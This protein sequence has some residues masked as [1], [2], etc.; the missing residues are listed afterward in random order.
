[1]HTDTAAWQAFA[2]GLKA[3]QSQPP[4]EDPATAQYKSLLGDATTN[5]NRTYGTTLVDS[6]GNESSFASDLGAT[7][8]DR[9]KDADGAYLDPS[10]VTTGTF[11][12]GG[13][14]ASNPFSKAA[15]LVRNYQQQRGRTTNGYAAQGQLYS[16]AIQNQRGQ[17]TFGYQQGQDTLQKALQEYLTGQSRS[18]RDAGVTRDD[19]INNAG[20][21]GLGSLLGG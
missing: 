4:A 21:T 15:L 2:D 19:T 3:K 20:L 13:V 5:A 11:D 6:V 7:L 16:G 9:P 12:W 8:A 14:Q 10:A 18:R 17:D 1:V